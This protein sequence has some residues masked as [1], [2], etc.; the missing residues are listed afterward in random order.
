MYRL[1]IVDDEIENVKWLKEMFQY[2]CEVEF[3]VY[4][5]YSGRQAL[6]ILN[7]IRMDVVLTDI[8]M[9]GMDGMELYRYIKEN[10][11]MAKV[12][13]L[14]GHRNYEILYEIIRNKEVSYILKTEGDD[15]IKR[16]VVEAV[17]ELEKSQQELAS[18]KESEA[19]K[20]KARYW[21]QKDF[22][23]NL[24]FGMIQDVPQQLLD[25]LGIPV[26][27]KYPLL[28]FIGRVR[29]WGEDTQNIYLKQA[30]LL[31]RIEEFMPITVRIFGCFVEMS[32]VMILIQPKILDDYVDW[33][34]IFNISEG[35]LEYVLES[36][37]KMAEAVDVFAV[38]ECPV[39]LTEVPEC[40]EKLKR[41]ILRKQIDQGIRILKLEKEDEEEQLGWDGFNILSCMPMLESLLEHREWKEYEKL[42]KKMTSSLSMVKSMHDTEALTVYYS[43]SIM[44]LKFINLNQLNEKFSFYIATYKLTCAEEHENWR[45]AVSYL[46][47]ISKI[48]FD[49][50]RE[51]ENRQT[52]I[53]VKRVQKYIREN[54]DKELTLTTLSEVAGFNASY[55]S[56]IFK[57]NCRMNVSEYIVKERMNEAKRLLIETNLKVNKIAEAV[58]YYSQH[59]FN[60]VFKSTEEITPLEYRNKYKNG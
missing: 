47:Q 2:E 46:F 19:L 13:F 31:D 4:T 42:L 27:Q 3:D 41:C 28:C 51:E 53:S 58:G 60:R 24:I 56:R 40:Y 49:L 16:A 26:K 52:N 32:Y 21:L 10:W 14:T 15:E 17:R 36:N 11:P 12:V 7:E 20:E 30:E 1:L 37:A 34:R 39:I 35:S 6:N 22:V 9:P 50:L 18:Q 5:A 59:S 48:L 23:N 44:L 43:I 57:Q 45:E 8:Q 33:K 38:S 55:L 54:L 25:D 29:M